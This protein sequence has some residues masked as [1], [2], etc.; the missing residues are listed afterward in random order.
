MS[1]LIDGMTVIVGF[2]DVDEDV[3]NAAA[4]LHDGVWV[5]YISQA[6]SAKLC[7]I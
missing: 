5:A 6:I 7:C 1:L 2:A 4:I 3:Y